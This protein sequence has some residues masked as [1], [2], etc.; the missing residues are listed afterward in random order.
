MKQLFLSAS[1][2][3]LLMPVACRSNHTALETTTPK[4]QIIQTTIVHRQQLA[5]ELVL[6]ARIV[7][8]PTQTV[9][10]YPLISGRVLS[11]SILPGQQVRKGERIGTIES[12]DATQAR[13]DFEKARIEAG[14]ADLQLNRAGE[15]LAHDVV[16]QRD[17]DDAKA[18][19]QS[20]HA[21][22]ERTRQALHI[23]GLDENGTSNIV[24]IVAPISGV[25]LDV[26]TGPGELQR[27]L[28]NATPIAT[29]ADIDSVWVVGDLYPRDQAGV[30][31]GQSAAIAVNGYPGL[32][33]HGAVQNI[34]DAVDPAT[35]TL[36]VRVEVPNP[37]HRLKPD[38]F[39]NMTL[40]TG[41]RETIEVPSTA[42][43]RNGNQSFVFVEASPGKYDRRNVS[44]SGTES[45]YDEVTQGL[46]DGDAVVITGSELLRDAGS[47]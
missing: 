28:D 8:N 23:L 41:K 36:K 22:L 32:L 44:L 30:R 20:D 9:H 5:N 21:D 7:A 33:L 13:D 12:S 38:M 14:R 16:A 6:P 24:P 3:L 42:V 15:L 35:L 2:A 43:I 45:S 11:L 25:V 19:D 40:T 34:S 31:T 39:A 18:L 10:I 46:S 27:S 1:T 29:V 37:G 4:Q 26:G 47:Q 17:Y